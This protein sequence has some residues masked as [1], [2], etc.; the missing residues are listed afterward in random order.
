MATLN[1]YGLKIRNIKA[2]S[3]STVDNPAGYSQISYDTATGELLETWHAGSPMTSWTQYREGSVITVVNTSR[4][5]T[6]QQLADA[7]HMALEQMR[8]TQ[9][10]VR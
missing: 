1:T 5:M 8:T 4:H 3:G 2:V 7:V 9:G 10:G 6:M